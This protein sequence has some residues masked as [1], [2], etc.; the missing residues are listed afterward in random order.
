MAKGI[1]KED[2]FASCRI[3]TILR[4]YKPLTVWD[5][6][7]EVNLIHREACQSRAQTLLEIVVPTLLPC[8]LESG[9]NINV[10]NVQKMLLQLGTTKG[11][12]EALATCRN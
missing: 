10:Y 2:A 7:E 8:N 3:S 9:K 6:N 11:Q 4:N 12:S 1:K 5:M